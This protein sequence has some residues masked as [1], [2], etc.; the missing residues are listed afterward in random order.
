MTRDAVASSV[1]GAPRASRPG[2]PDQ[3]GLSSAEAAARLARD[4]S[5]VLPE[6]KQVARSASESR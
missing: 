6:T 5:N 2:E 1:V 4:G 3:R